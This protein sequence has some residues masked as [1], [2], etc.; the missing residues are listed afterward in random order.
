DFDQLHNLRSSA[1]LEAYG[2]L[3]SESLFAGSETR[4]FYN[5]VLAVMRTG[6]VP[7]RLRLTIDTGAQELHSLLWETLC[8]PN[9]GSRLTTDDGILFT[10]FVADP[11]SRPVTLR[12]RYAANALVAIAAHGDLGKYW[13][14]PIEVQAEVSKARSSLGTLPVTILASDSDS[15]P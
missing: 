14:T 8:D 10:R 13:Q 3:L 2:R 12:P 4:A 1:D 5:G 6:S 15:T 11:T 9:N 7:L